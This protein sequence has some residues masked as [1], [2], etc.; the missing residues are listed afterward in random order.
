MAG[1]GK[2]DT[3]K[4][5]QDTARLK[6]Y[7]THGPGAVKIRWGELHDFDRCVTHLSKYVPPGEV[8]GLCANLHHD[9]LGVWPGQEDGK[10]KEVKHADAGDAPLI[11]VYE[12]EE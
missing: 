2:E 8:K 11:V 1:D 4:D 6:W 9:A 5:V 12:N 7:W 3:P 10:A